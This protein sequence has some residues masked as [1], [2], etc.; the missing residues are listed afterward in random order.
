MKWHPASFTR[1]FSSLYHAFTLDR[2]A[3]SRRTR[4]VKE[5]SGGFASVSTVFGPTGPIYLG[6][7][8]L[9]VSGVA[10]SRKWSRAR[11]GFRAQRERAPGFCGEQPGRAP[12]KRRGPHEWSPFTSSRTRKFVKSRGDPSSRLPEFRAID[13][14]HDSR[15]PVLSAGVVHAFRTA[16]ADNFPLGIR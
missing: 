16:H 15:S 9:W 4:R 12:G 5:G 13:N 8:G 1:R 2:V 10:A 3:E 7:P 11:S 6:N 14:S